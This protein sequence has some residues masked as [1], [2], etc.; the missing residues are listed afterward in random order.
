M[1]EGAYI[2][3]LQCRHG[4]QCTAVF[5]FKY[6]FAVNHFQ[7]LVQVISMYPSDLEASS[8]QACIF[9]PRRVHCTHDGYWKTTVV[10]MYI[11]IHVSV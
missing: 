5:S 6:I 8:V 2:T 11:F 10:L 1:G 4:R 3:H 7:D 9:I